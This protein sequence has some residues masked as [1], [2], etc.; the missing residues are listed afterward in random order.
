MDN[1]ATQDGSWL[2]PY[3]D[4]RFGALDEATRDLRGRVSR[5]EQV[6]AERKGEDK[7]R[8][9]LWRWIGE[10][11]SYVLVALVSAFASRYLSH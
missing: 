7:V 6:G 3:L 4:S 1:E 11:S 8:Q 5:L 2:R 9:G 10:K